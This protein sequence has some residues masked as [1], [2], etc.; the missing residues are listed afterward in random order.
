MW[1][2]REMDHKC[3]IEEGTLVRDREREKER[4]R[5][6]EREREK[7]SALC[8]LLQ[9]GKQPSHRQRENCNLKNT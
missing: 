2:G 7:Q 6:R 8:L 9:V 3:C 4:E 5:E 1:F